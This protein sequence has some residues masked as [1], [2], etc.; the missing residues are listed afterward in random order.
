MNNETMQKGSREETGRYTDQGLQ[1]SIDTSTESMTVALSRGDTLLCE[2]LSKAER[3]HSLY[4]VPSIHKIMNEAGVKP[5]DLSAVAVGVGPGSYTGI[6][7]G[8]TVAKTYAWTHKLALLGVSTLEAIALGGAHASAAEGA[9]VKLN[10]IPSVTGQGAGAWIVPL[11]DA[12]RGQV[13]TGLYAA[14]DGWSGLV[15]DGIRL[16][17]LWTEQLFERLEDTDGMP[18]RIIFTGELELH[19]EAIAAFAGKWSGGVEVRPYA[20]GARAVAELGR[21]RWQ[22]GELEDVHGLVPNYTQLAEAE[23]KLLAAKKC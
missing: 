23:A 11:I 10:A 18:G 12:R 3:N 2:I 5:R 6:R 1:L 20:L 13:F 22:R 19:R 21:Q 8:V 14:G 15:K 4:L 7:I 16:M 17:S 9:G